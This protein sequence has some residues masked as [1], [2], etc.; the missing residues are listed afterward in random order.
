[1]SGSASNRRTSNVGRVL[2]R[3]VMHYNIFEYFVNYLAQKN[4][5]VNKNKFYVG[6][7]IYY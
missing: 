2:L 3:A 7:R 4:G 5:I 1:M 6:Q